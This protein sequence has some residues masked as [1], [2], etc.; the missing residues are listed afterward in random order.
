M[1]IQPNPF[2]HV[3]TNFLKNKSFFVEIRFRFVSCPL[4][5]ASVGTIVS[6]RAVHSSTSTSGNT[7]LPKALLRAPD[8]QTVTRSCEPVLSGPV[9]SDRTQA[10]RQQRSEHGVREDMDRGTR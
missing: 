3:D 2:L 5:V 9:A 4:W 7:M 6:D 8:T 1:P 10:P